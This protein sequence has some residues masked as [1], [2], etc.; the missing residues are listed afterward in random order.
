MSPKGATYL[1]C[2]D[3]SPLFRWDAKLQPSVSRTNSSF[4]ASEPSSELLLHY[5]SSA[6]RTRP[7]A[8]VEVYTFFTNF[9]ATPFMQ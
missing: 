7:L 5:Q 8:I 9:N 6:S 4:T 1:K 2:G 3:L